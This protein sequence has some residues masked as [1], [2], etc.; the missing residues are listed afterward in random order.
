MVSSVRAAASPCVCCC[1][2]AASLSLELR[3]RVG[4][5]PHVLARLG[6]VALDLG[7]AHRALLRGGA[8]RRRQLLELLDAALF[9]LELLREALALAAHLVEARLQ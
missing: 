7:D 8:Q 9:D 4:E 3:V 1:A 6:C 5:G 2:A